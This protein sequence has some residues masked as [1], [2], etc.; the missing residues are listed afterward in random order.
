MCYISQT[1]LQLGSRYD[2]GSNNQRHLHETDR[3]KQGGV[4]P[5]LFLLSLLAIMVMVTL[6]FAVAALA[7][8]LVLSYQIYRS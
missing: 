7:E 5:P 3:Q 4:L 6:D 2:Q 1:C 8:I